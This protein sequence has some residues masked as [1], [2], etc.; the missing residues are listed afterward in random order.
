MT[1]LLA[2]PVARWA[3][4]LAKFIV[5]MVW[6]AALTVLIYIIGLI[7]GA[8]IGLP[9]GSMSVLS[10]GSI[11]LAV[12][13]A[14]VLAVM[15]PV[16]FFASAGRGYLLPMGVTILL[17]LFAN[18]LVVAGW[19]SYFPWSVPALYAGAGGSPSAGLEPVSY[20]IVALTGLAGIMGTLLWWRFAD[21]SR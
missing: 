21:Q 11:V 12:T 5:V 16:A 6:S 18:V 3:I 4:L 7:L 20:W 9:Q 17:V 14:M 1:D 15:T 13:T 8:L 2:V 19:G 10:Q